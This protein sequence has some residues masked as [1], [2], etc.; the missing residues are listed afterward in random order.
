MFEKCIEGTLESG[1]DF[2]KRTLVLKLYDDN[3]K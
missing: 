1:I 2:E 3:A